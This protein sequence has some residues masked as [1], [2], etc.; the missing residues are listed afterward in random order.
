MRDHTVTELLA[1]GGIAVGVAL[2]FGVLVANGSIV[3][4]VRE[5]VRAVGGSADL[6]FVARSPSTFS[7]GLAD[8]IASLPGVARSASLLRKYAVVEGPRGRQRVQFVGIDPS[9][10]S[11][12]GFATK[13]LGSGALLLARGVGLPSSLASIIGTEARQTVTLVINGSSS[14]VRVRAVLNSGA[15]GPLASV[16]LVAALLPYAQTIAGTPGQVNQVLIEPRPGRER[17]VAGEL[18]ALGDLP[19]DLVNA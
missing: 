6:E 4:S 3:G 13:N 2:V 1:G 19:T 16:P 11:L 12:G 9:L 14:R 10:I 8:R 18:R 17:E 15:I 5:D 7:V